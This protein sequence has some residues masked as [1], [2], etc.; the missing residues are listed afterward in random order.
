MEEIYNQLLI[1]GFVEN[2]EE[3]SARWCWRSKS[4]FA[5]QRNKGGDFTIEVAINCLNVTRVRIALAHLRRKQLGSIA[6]SDLRILNDVRSKLELYLLE[7]HRI[8][9]VAADVPLV[10]KPI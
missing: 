9:A 8:T 10:K 7:Q 6:D 1:D 4:W 5:V 3:F 2:A